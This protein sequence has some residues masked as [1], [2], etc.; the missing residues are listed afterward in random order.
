MLLPRRGGGPARLGVSRLWAVANLVPGAA[1]LEAQVVLAA[2][3]S[4]A[5]V[6]TVA[7]SAVSVAVTVPSGFACVRLPAG[8]LQA[9]ADGDPRFR[10]LRVSGRGCLS[11]AVLCGSLK[12][13]RN[14]ALSSR[15]LCL[16]P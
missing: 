15:R 8:V 9:F 5:V 3:V 12:S 7:V 2:V 1:A 13:I 6:L 4:F 14:L 10:G 11:A 16:E